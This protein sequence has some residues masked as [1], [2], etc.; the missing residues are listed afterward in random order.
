MVVPTWI[1]VALVAIDVLIVITFVLQGFLIKHQD[2]QIDFHAMMIDKHKSHYDTA[3]Y[4]LEVLMDKYC[5]ETSKSIDKTNAS[6]DRVNKRQREMNEKIDGVLML[7]ADVIEDLATKLSKDI[8]EQAYKL[9]IKDRAA[10]EIQV[11]VINSFDMN[12][13][14]LANANGPMDEAEGNF[15]KVNNFGKPIYNEQD[16]DDEDCDPPHPS[17]LC[18][19]LFNDQPKC[20]GLLEE[21]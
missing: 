21:D 11:N 20:S 15:V 2:E 14:D 9:F 13:Q 6:I 4:N 12:E 7:P 3:I 19:P 10:S 1:V 5:N 16:V 18:E 8:G 17:E